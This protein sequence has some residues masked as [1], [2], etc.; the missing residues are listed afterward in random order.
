MMLDKQVE[1][2][3]KVLRQGKK[4]GARNYPMECA[5]VVLW[6]M[7]RGWSNAA[8]SR[9][10][11]VHPST[12]K[13]YKQTFYKRPWNVFGSPVLHRGVKGGKTLW[14]CQVCGDEMTGSEQKAREHVAGHMVPM[15]II[16]RNGV[17][18]QTLD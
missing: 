9:L 10:V 3:I 15:E 17:M 2:A 7:W 4:A 11:G 14:T 5:L 6:G 18:P 1:K 13:R 8:I 12:I 16:K